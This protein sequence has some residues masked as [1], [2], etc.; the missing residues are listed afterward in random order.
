[1]CAIPPDTSRNVTELI[2]KKSVVF[3]VVTM[4]GLEAHVIMVRFSGAYLPRMTV[5]PTFVKAAG[6]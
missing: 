1:M 3:R 5:G 6:T 2:T 4:L